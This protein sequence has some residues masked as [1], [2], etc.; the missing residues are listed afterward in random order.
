MAP[1]PAVGRLESLEL[2]DARQFLILV[3]RLADSLS[4]GTDHSPFLGSGIEF[5]QSR[6]Y[7][8][9]DPVRLIDWRVT[10]RTGRFHV[11]EY[12]S[13]KRMPVHLLLDTSAS[14]TV[15]S[16][17]RSKYA[18]A[19]YIAGGIALACL[20]RVSPVGVIG[21]GTRS[22]R[23]WPSLSKPQILMWL[24]ALRTFRYDEG[25]RLA[26]R[27]QELTPRLTH[28]VLMI[29]LSDL[30]DPSALPALKELAA[31]HD[32][33]VLQLQDP[34]ER[35]LRGTGFLRARE[36]ETG[37]ALWTHGRRGHLDQEATD[38]ALR[39][40]GIDHLV[41]RTDRPYVHDLRRFFASRGLLGRGPR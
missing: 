39:R 27:I 30:H 24:L 34:A 5:V 9:G 18:T 20:D 14:M 13:P 3:R 33:A 29:V 8:A 22:F 17:A 38:R 15:S 37:R 35:R 21:V 36:A 25:T 41:I 32:C 40:S 26:R 10:A 23:I 7:A 11:K 28:R 6:P 4:Y 16:T 1:D 2:L 19:L 31:R 12:E